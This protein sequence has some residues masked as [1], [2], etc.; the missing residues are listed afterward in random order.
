MSSQEGTGW[1]GPKRRRLGQGLGAGLL[2]TELLLSSSRRFWWVP[3][4]LPS[5][6]QRALHWRR[7]STVSSGTLGVK[8]SERY[9]GGL[10]TLV[11]AHAGHLLGSATSLFHPFE[12]PRRKRPCKVQTGKPR[13]RR[14]TISLGQGV[15]GQYQGP[16]ERFLPLPKVPTAAPEM[17]NGPGREA[18]E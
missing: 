5:P 17:G 3:Q 13:L 6:P 18:R 14:E 11:G 15:G 8:E 1:V 12:N 2:S 9:L 7:V 4:P 10:L 16:E